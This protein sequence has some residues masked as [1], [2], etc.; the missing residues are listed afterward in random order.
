M[1]DE[2]APAVREAIAKAVF[3]ALKHGETDD[4]WEICKASSGHAHNWEIADALFAD[5]T[6]LLVL[7]PPSAES[8]RNQLAVAYDP[9]AFDFHP[10]ETRLGGAHL[11]WA[12]RRKLARDAADR[13]LASGVLI[14]NAPYIHPPKGPCPFCRH[15]E[16]A[17]Y[18]CLNMASDNE[19]PC[20]LRVRAAGEV[21][22]RG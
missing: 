21:F 5:P 7:L 17:G 9:D 3:F 19:C 13:L 11:Q 14:Q 20:D 8:A 22:G 2:A 1:S 15:A 6:P 4:D 18:R 10:V 12:A 16:H